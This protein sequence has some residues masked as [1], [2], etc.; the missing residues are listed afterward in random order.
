MFVRRLSVALT[1]AFALA[2]V[3][4]PAPAADQPEIVIGSILPLTG[5]LAQTGAGLRTA[6]ELAVDLVNGHVS[7]PLP[8]VG[9]SG[10]PHLAH[11]RIRRVNQIR[12]APPQSS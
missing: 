5:A 11:A 1:A 4:P 9:H 2:A 7:Y 12:R 10:I 8:A 3:A 6:Q